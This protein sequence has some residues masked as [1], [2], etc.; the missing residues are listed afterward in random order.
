MEHCPFLSPTKVHEL[1]SREEIQPLLEG[2]V[3]KLSASLL[4]QTKQKPFSLL[5]L[6]SKSWSI[7]RILNGGLDSSLA[8]SSGLKS[9]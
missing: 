2:N 4:L 1:K 9:Y 5:P 8:P 6:S 7:S 3:S